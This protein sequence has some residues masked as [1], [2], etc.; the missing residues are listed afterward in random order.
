MCHYIT[1]ILAPGADSLAVKRMAK[2]HLLKWEFIENHALR[3]TLRDGETYY[4]TTNGMCD[5]GTGL[6]ML[7]EDRGVREPDYKRKAKRLRKKG[8]SDTKIERWMEDK[9]RDRQQAR[10]RNANYVTNPP[11]DVVHWKEFIVGVLESK[12]SRYLGLLVHWYNGSIETES[13]NIV[14][15]TWVIY[16]DVDCEYLLRASE[17]VIHTF[18]LDRHDGA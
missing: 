7:A 4:T 6:G 13:I 15:R 14:D 9:Q 3:K 10:S 5:C 12:A 8:W 16:T 18:Y 2:A 1:G 11:I 17:D